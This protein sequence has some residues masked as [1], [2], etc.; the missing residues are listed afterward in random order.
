M[1]ACTYVGKLIGLI[2]TLNNPS[3]FIYRIFHYMNRFVPKAWATRIFIKNQKEYLKEGAGDYL[4]ETYDGS[5]QAVHPDI[6]Y[7]KD[8]YW[9]VLT[10]YPYGMEEYE[11][12]CIYSGDTLENLTTPK[13]PVAVQRKHTQGQHLS[14][15]C[16]AVNGDHLYCYYRESERKGNTEE[17]TV[18]EIR[19]HELNKTWEDP[20]LIMDS[21]DDKILSPA[22]IFNS[23]GVLTIYYVSSL[24]SGFSLV[25]TKS[26]GAITDITEQKVYGIPEDYEL[27]HIGVSKKKDIF[28]NAIDTSELMGLFLAKA[29]NRNG[30]MKLF[31]ARNNGLNADWHIIKEIE[32]PNEIKNIVAF[33]YKSC[34][35]PKQDGKLLLSFRDNKSRNRMII[36]CNK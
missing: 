21:V 34:F 28:T 14:D 11:N 4:I 15:P 33:P 26:K 2:K 30:D 5:G 17:N 27:W 18:W 10:P 6:A 20:E 35:I 19:Y 24:N 7:W 31:E 12:P 3:F 8:K 29:K 22:M 16:F 25:S 23:L 36:M 1:G 9:L 13:G 32:M